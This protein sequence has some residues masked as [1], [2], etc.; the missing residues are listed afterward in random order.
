MT[1]T[2]HKKNDVLQHSL[3]VRGI[4]LFL[5]SQR[6]PTPLT[7]MAYI[8]ARHN[9]RLQVRRAKLDWSINKCN[10]MNDGYHGP[11]CNKSP[12][13]AVKLL[14]SGLQPRQ[15]APPPKLKCAD[16]SIAITLEEVAN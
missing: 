2:S 9:A 10:A 3:F 13:E 16:G 14:K 12:W 7:R 6:T 11:S 15:R 5:C 8:V 4:F 1:V